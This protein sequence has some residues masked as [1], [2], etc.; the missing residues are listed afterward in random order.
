MVTWLK[1]G[2]RGL[3]AREILDH[4]ARVEADLGL[5]SDPLPSRYLRIGSWFVRRDYLLSMGVPGKSGSGDTKISDFCLDPSAKGILK[6]LIARFVSGRTQSRTT[7]QAVRIK[8]NLRAYYIEGDR[9]FTTKILIGN[10]RTV[11]NMQNEIETRLRVAGYDTLKAPRLLAHN[12][13]NDPPYFSEELVTGR[14]TNASGDADLIVKRLC[15]QLW[16]TYEREGIS[17]Q[18][19]QDLLDTSEALE[20]MRHACSLIP[21]RESWKDRTA[22]LSRFGDLLEEDACMPVSTG[23]GDLTPGNMITTEDGEIFL[24]DW[25]L[26]RK[27]PIVLDLINLLRIVPGAGDYFASKM[28]QL[29]AMNRDCS[30]FPFRDQCFLAAVMPVLEWKAHRRYLHNIGAGNKTLVRKLTRRI[31]RAHS[32]L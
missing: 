31:E 16:K 30:V 13:A 2:L 21:W 25:E 18:R 7:A 1:R 17:F 24:V 26:S 4:V 8:N 3:E 5:G 11:G 20:E 10:T 32:F 15:P 23:H 28:G 29:I 22:F 9:P 12:L 27:M 19:I 14:R 6:W